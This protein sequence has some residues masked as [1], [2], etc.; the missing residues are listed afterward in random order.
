MASSHR[1]MPSR[2]AQKRKAAPPANCGSVWG[3]TFGYD[4]FG[5]LTKSGSMSFQPTYSASTNRM[6]ALPG[7]T[8]TYDANGNVLNDNSPA[9]TWDAENRPVTQD[10]IGFTIDA[11][12]RVVEQNRSGAYTQIVYAPTGEKLALMNGQTLQKAFIPLPG[13]ATA[14][15][16]SSGLSYYRHPDWLGS[17]RFSS[18]PSRTMYSDVAY[19]PFGEPYA[20]A[21]TTDLSFTG[22]NQDTVSNLYD[23]PAREYGIQG[24]WASPDPA[25]LAVID[26]VNPQSWNRYTYVLGN[27]LGLIDPLGLDN[28]CGG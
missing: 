15:Y 22:M 8:P 18:T 11:L 17:A 25:G 9:Y 23:F 4:P 21:G 19:A 12:N 28:D 3:Q 1:I 27:P 20:Q 26:T 14:V 10:G 5:N 6:T 7:F 13:R 24:R 16:T 2:R